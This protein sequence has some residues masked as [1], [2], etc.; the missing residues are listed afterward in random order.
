ML[1]INLSEVRYAGRFKIVKKIGDTVTYEGAWQDNLITDNGLNLL[2]T[3]SNVM[4]QLHLSADNTEPSVTDTQ[5]TSLIRTVS[6]SSSAINY[7]YVAGQPYFSEQIQVYTFAPTVPE[8]AYNCSKVYLSAGDPNSVFSSALIKDS[9]GLPT[10]LSI[11]GKETLEV[12][13]AVRQYYDTS[14]KTSTMPLSLDLGTPTIETEMYNVKSQVYLPGLGVI[15]NYGWSAVKPS[16]KSSAGLLG[17]DNT[18]FFVSGSAM[19]LLGSYLDNA[20]DIGVNSHTNKEYV[21]NSLKREVTVGFSRF[22]G[23]YTNGLRSIVIYT[24][25]GIYCIEY[26]SQIT[27]KAIPKTDSDELELNFEMSWGRYVAP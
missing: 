12:F 7:P 18:E 21:Q 22:Q 26:T 13:Y 24:S 14:V 11:R 23:N 16:G 25:R 5:V 2:G 4:A 1:R 8:A 15:N 6:G 19:P 17:S 20:K 3:A 9:N 10:T 27:G